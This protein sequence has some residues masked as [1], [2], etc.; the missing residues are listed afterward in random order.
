MG[1]LMKNK[2]GV[3]EALLR[4]EYQQPALVPALN[5]G[6][7][8]PSALKLS[9]RMT[10]NGVEFHGDASA[11]FLIVQERHDDGTWHTRILPGKSFTHEQAAPSA[12][13]VRA[14]DKF[15]NVGEPTVLARS[16]P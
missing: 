14:L 11:R 13:A 7:Q 4:S 1:A 2:G 5:S 3:D 10:R 9:V 6:A 8:K 15:G 12:M 16:Q